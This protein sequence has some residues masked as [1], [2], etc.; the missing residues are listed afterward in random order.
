MNNTLTALVVKF[1]M[2]FLLATI[3]FRFVD[4]NTWQWILVVSV[5]STLLNYLVG[6]LLVLPTLGNAVASVGDGLMGALLA[7]AVAV[8]IPEFSASFAGLAVFAVTV[9]LGE[10]FFH[11]FL[12][13]ADKVAP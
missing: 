5:A 10:Y 3:A 2:T 8:Y 12:L 7:Y 4:A 6:D 9:A 11:Q 1:V 13:S